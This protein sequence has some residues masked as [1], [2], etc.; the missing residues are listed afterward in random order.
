VQE[1]AINPGAQLPAGSF[2]EGFRT[3][4][5]ARCARAGTPVSEGLDKLAPQTARATQCSSPKAGS[6]LA[7]LQNAPPWDQPL[8]DLEA[9]DFAKRP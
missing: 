8:S 4:P 2:P 3:P 7:A 6:G 5:L 1:T 9:G